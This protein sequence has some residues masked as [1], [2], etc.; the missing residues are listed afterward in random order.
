MNADLWLDNKKDTKSTT[1]YIEIQLKSVML[2]CYVT[3]LFSFS[4][5]LLLYP[6]AVTWT[7]K[8][9]YTKDYIQWA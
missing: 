9:L 4:V 5:L 3:D 7:N 1:K 6:H 8:A 2:D